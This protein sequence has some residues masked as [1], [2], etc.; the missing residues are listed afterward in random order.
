[1]LL[2]GSLVLLGGAG[3]STEEVLEIC[4][5]GCPY[6]TL[7]AALEAAYPGGVTLLLHPG[8]YP[9]AATVDIGFVTIKGVDRDK[10]ILTAREKYE[11]VLRVRNREVRIEN[12]TFKG[13]P[14][15]QPPQFDGR[16]FAELA[17][18]ILPGEFHEAQIE[19]EGVTFRD[20]V[21]RT[22]SILGPRAKLSMRGSV[23]LRHERFGSADIEVA[24]GA[25]AE[26]F[27]NSLDVPVGVG[28][29]SSLELSVSGLPAAGGSH[30][31]FR[32][33]E[34]ALLSV[35]EESSALVVGN[36]FSLPYY[37]FGLR[38]GIGG[39]V[40]LLDNIFEPP[41]DLE[42]VDDD[43]YLFN[44]GIR[45]FSASSQAVLEA[46]NNQIR[47]FAQGISISEGSRLYLQS[48]TLEDNKRAIVVLM[49]NAPPSLLEMWENRIEGSQD[50]GI[51]IVTVD[52][53]RQALTII[54]EENVF[55]SN[56]QD[57]CPSGYP[58]PPDFIKNP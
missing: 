12:L 29:A 5:Q 20:W 35:G 43:I 36:R 51:R 24:N 26:F 53:A 31:E 37:G 6:A 46:R 32:G 7:E 11:P 34:L 2:I 22:I 15:P 38:M 30:A 39:R 42:G 21:G 45:I 57:L 4:A 23:V 14:T 49:R 13:N 44:T 41:A 25:T 33:N 9:T 18:Q 10:V 58:W 8:T 40:A 1:M 27:E 50:C 56:Q 3:G 54:G 28:R 55:V 17:L 52:A 48:N 47:S 16:E 19:I